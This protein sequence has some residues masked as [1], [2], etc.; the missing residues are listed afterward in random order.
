MMI[1]KRSKIALF[2]IM[3]LLFI[4]IIILSSHA[5]TN[6]TQEIDF[7]EAIKLG[8]ENNYELQTLRNNIVE[9]ERNLEILDAS[10][11]FQVNLSITPIWH[12][13]KSTE[14]K[15]TGEYVV[16]MN[17]TSLT[18]STEASLIATKQLADNI[19]LS[20]ELTWQSDN[21]FKKNLTDLT[22]EINANLRLNKRLYPDSWSENKKQ[23]YSIK[24]NLQ[25]RLEELRW[26]EIEKQIEFIGDYLN[27]L[28]LQEQ[29][30]IL[31]EH[32]DL[33]E[34]ELARVQR[35]IELG[36]GGYQQ[37]VEAQIMLKE[38]ENSLLNQQQNLVRAKKQ[39]FLSLNLPKNTIVIFE[40]NIDFIEDL[41]S[42]MANL[43]FDNKNEDDLLMAA[44]EENYRTKNSQLEKEKLAKE[45]EWTKDEGK[46]KVD[47]SGGYQFPADWFVMLDFSIKLADGGVQ[48]LKEQ[49]KIDN[50]EQKDVSI[51]HLNEQ[52]KLEAE[53][54][55]GQDE[56]NK[57][58][59]DIQR[60]ALE[61][62]QDMIKIREIQYNQGVISLN[63]LQ[64]AI[65]SFR[66]KEIKVKQAQD[67]W[68]INRLKLAHF[69]GYLQE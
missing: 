48:K 17:T 18:P 22:D 63:N 1:N 43:Q 39:W 36:E 51:A 28:R 58:N 40:D 54:L 32:L 38:L 42:Q 56:Y 7:K 49:Q 31:R 8:L 44:L 45:L 35:L 15:E 67:E 50:I 23:A 13:G 25:I 30:H 59:R 16:K 24:N 55:L 57:L 19:S 68:F 53:H 14:N 34:E 29:V 27:I 9:L 66:E 3:F 62:E 46:A 33:I 11:S 69:I 61:K 12:F 52:I 2:L 41:Y 65:L 47:I 6:K 26:E 37:E 64:N 5:E 20:T 21:L 10:E 4:S 60:M